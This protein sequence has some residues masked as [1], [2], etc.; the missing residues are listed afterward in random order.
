MFSRPYIVKLYNVLKVN[1][2]KAKA[3][4]QIVSLQKC[5]NIYCFFKLNLNI[6][7]FNRFF[8]EGDSVDLLPL[9]KFLILTF[10]NRLIVH[11][12]RCRALKKYGIHLKKILV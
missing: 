10:I 8:V 11:H 3:Y 4:L 12:L 7:V 9:L 6:L 1:E 2:F 5:N